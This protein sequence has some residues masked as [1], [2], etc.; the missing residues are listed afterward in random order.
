MGVGPLVAAAG[1]ALLARVGTDVNYATDLLPAMLLFALGLAMTVAPLTTTVLDSV[2]ERHVG[3]ASGVNNAVARVAGVLAIAALGAVIS[4]QFTSSLDGKIA[5]QSLSPEA[6]KSIDDAKDQPLSGGD[7]SEVPAAEADSLDEDI[8]SSSE[9]AFNLG[10]ALGAALMA[11]G[12][13]ISLVAVR[14]PKPG[15]EPEQRRGP[16][17]AATAG[18]CGRCPPTE[19]PKVKREPEPEPLPG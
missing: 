3:V 7:V 15:E 4:A 12:G 19:V 11:I 16:G 17:S 1:L 6:T 2:D 8:T 14:N 18:E 5:G 9:S 10:M 13:L